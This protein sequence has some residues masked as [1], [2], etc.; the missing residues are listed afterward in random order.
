M[1]PP[2]NQTAC[3]H[4][5]E[6][7]PLQPVKL[8]DGRVYNL[9]RHCKQ[10]AESATGR[11]PGVKYEERRYTPSLTCMRRPTMDQQEKNGL[12]RLRARQQLGEKLSFAEEL[13]LLGAKIP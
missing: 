1:T 7:K 4:C 12:A 11:L 13:E 9:C 2:S 5:V 10:D 6:P 8:S 3:A